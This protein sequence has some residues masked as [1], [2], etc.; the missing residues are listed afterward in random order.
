[1]IRVLAWMLSLSSFTAVCSQFGFHDGP[2]CC[3]VRQWWSGIVLALVILCDSLEWMDLLTAACLG[4]ASLLLL[5]TITV[6]EALRATHPRIIIMIAAS[7]ALGSALQ[8]TGVAT[9]V[10]KSLVDITT[11]SGRFGLLLGVS[12]ATSLI[13]SLVSNNACMVLMFPVCVTVSAKPSSSLHAAIFRQRDI[14]TS[15]FHLAP[16]VALTR[17]TNRRTTSP[18]RCP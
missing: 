1:M 16:F 13:N 14:R 10:A 17:V 3:S 6:D 2:C 12:I 11:S 7:F 4:V 9:W 8:N 15:F 5:R 18:Q